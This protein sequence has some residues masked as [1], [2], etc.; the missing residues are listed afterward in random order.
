MSHEW[1][2]KTKRNIIIIRKKD[3]NIQIHNERK[4]GTKKERSRERKKKKTKQN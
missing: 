1:K 2:N 4:A 3:R